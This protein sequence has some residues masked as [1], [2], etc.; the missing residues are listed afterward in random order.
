MKS[1]N[2]AFSNLFAKETDKK[3]DVFSGAD[4]EAINTQM[5]KQ[6][7]MDNGGFGNAPKFPQTLS[8]QFLLAYGK[9]FDNQESLNHAKLS[10]NSLRKSVLPL[11]NI[12]TA[13]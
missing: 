11:K 9:L 8:I 6:A 7:D 1:N 5:L 3:T 13:L 4:F 2:E 12:H 10:M